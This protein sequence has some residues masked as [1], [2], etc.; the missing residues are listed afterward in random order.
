M[1]YFIV[2]KVLIDGRSDK[3]HKNQVITVENSKIVGIAPL[4]A[5]DPGELKPD[6]TYYVDYALP[7]LVDCH[8]HLACDVG[9]QED[10]MRQHT[11]YIALRVARNART[12][13]LSGVTTMRTTGEKEGIDFAYR[14]AIKEWIVPGPR[15]LAPGA[16]IG[17][18]GAHAW[19]FLTEQ[20]DGPEAFRDA[21]RRRRRAGADFIK[22]MV[23]GGM[24]TPDSDFMMAE[25][26]LEE[27]KAAVDEA[28]RWGKR[29]A[30][31][32]HGGQALDYA[33]EAGV[34]TIEHG[35]FG[36]EEQY[37]KMAASGQ[38]LIATVNDI[39]TYAEEGDKY[40]VPIYAQEKCKTGFEI[41]CKAMAKARELGVK[42]A[43][44]QD[45]IHGKLA[46]EL[47]S[48]VKYAGF[49][50]MDAIKAA[51]AIGAEACGLESLTGTIEVGKEADVIGVKTNP[52][53]DIV[54]LR[55]IAFVMKQGRPCLY[56]GKVLV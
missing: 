43:V 44:G 2:A 55:E 30:A 23:S 22:L 51:T 54:A 16:P 17:V 27:L 49:S 12:E 34:T 35:G 37:A 1:K 50:T 25:I 53:E 45:C 15:I 24:M 13:L 21:V 3:P 8:N 31:H 38:Y 36:T 14:R 28:K 40:G 52:L 29:T 5:L 33:I 47:I 42:I 56:E 20:V 46:E 4:E 19:T 32:I 10:Q 18:T 11:A 41:V 7:G 26:T 9:D 6:S 39:R 48:L